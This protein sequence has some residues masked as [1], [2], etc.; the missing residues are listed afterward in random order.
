MGEK[1]TQHLTNIYKNLNCRQVCMHG[2]IHFSGLHV[3]CTLNILQVNFWILKW[4]SWNIL[5]IRSTSHLK[6]KRLLMRNRK[7][8]IFYTL[9]TFAINMFEFIRFGNLTEI[10]WAS[11]IPAMIKD[12]KFAC[13]YHTRILIQIQCIIKWNS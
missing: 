4:H 8:V 6:R 2:W 13:I 3:Y 9:N 5:Y 1:R 11:L 7:Y 10:L 12:L